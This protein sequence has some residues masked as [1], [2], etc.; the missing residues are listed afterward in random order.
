MLSQSLSGP[1]VFSQEYLYL[2]MTQMGLGD[3]DL[4]NRPL[5][6]IHPQSSVC[7]GLV[8]MWLLVTLSLSLPNPGGYLKIAP[9][10]NMV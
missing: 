3:C 5:F 8:G 1:P 4:Y 10:H 7:L 6:S 2:K 9:S